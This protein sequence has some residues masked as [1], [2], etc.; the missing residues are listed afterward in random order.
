MA[1]TLYNDY[2]EQGAVIIHIVIEDGPDAGTTIDW[3][4]AR[5]WAND[6]N[7]FDNDGT[8]EPLQ[9]IIVVADTDRGLWERYRHPCGTDVA[10]QNSCYVTPQGQHL[11]QGRVVIDDPCAYP[12]CG[13]GCGYSD[14]RVRQIFGQVL[15][16]KW[17]GEAT[18]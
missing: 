12:N 2:R 11:D 1:N 15:P 6:I 10:C 9:G 14:T 17:C 7:D 16:A 18:Q 4:D 5:D 13:T 3:T 8:A